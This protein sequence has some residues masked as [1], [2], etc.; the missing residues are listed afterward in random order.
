MTARNRATLSAGLTIL[1][2]A[3]GGF[4]ARA[5]NSIFAFIFLGVTVITAVISGVYIGISWR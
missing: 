3:G 2:S 5:G 1:A 4:S